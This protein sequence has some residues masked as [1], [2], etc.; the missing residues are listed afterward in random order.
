MDPRDVQRVLV[1]E[2]WNI[3]DVVLLL[4]FLQQLRAI[5]P[6]ART[7][8]LAR[9]HARE[10]LAPS[11]LVD[12]FI[13][14]ELS[15]ERPRGGAPTYPWAELWRVV[16]ELRRRKFDIAFQGRPHVREYV[17]LGLSAAKRRVGLIRK[18][19]DRLLTDRIQV[20]LFAVQKREAWLRLLAP[21]GG[22]RQLVPPRLVPADEARQWT[23]QFLSSRGVSTEDLLIG[24][25]PGSS[26]AAKRWP[27]ERFAEVVEQLVE[28]PGVR[29][30]TFIEPTGYGAALEAEDRRIVARLD[31]PR[32]VAVLERCDLLVCNDSG[33]MHIAGALGVPCVAIFSAGIAQLFEP[34]GDGHRMLTPAESPSENGP[35]RRPP[36]YDVTGVPVQSVLGAIED[37]IG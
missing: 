5:F 34:L 29:V 18:G 15:W 20:D 22:S 37:A 11:G 3:G 4:P 30:V 28:R 36:P 35:V 19:W 1:L 25:H 12:E 23:T 2:L 9:P 13:E 32:L 14:T 21:F 27:I 17:I 6:N 26:V 7:V 8:L 10:L 33:P 24:I 16:R 31:L